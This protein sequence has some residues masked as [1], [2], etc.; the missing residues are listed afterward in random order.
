MIYRYIGGLEVLQK[1]VKPVKEAREEEL[2]RKEEGAA[3]IGETMG[4]MAID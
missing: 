2:T 3:A 1:A 4:H